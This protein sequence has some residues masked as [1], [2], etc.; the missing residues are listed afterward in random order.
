MWPC[1][2]GKLCRPPDE[3]ATSFEKL[4]SY[5]TCTQHQVQERHFSFMCK[6]STNL[7]RFLNDSTITCIFSGKEYIVT[8]PILC[9]VAKLCRPP[10]EAATSF[11]KFPLTSDAHDNIKCRRDSSHLPAYDLLICTDSSTIVAEVPFPEKE[12]VIT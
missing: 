5:L 6:R 4:F 11:E 1:E 12:C 7:Y 3:A 2:S 8:R 9:D 10:A